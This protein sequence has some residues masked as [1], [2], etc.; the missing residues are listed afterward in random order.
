MTIAE[1][2]KYIDAVKNRLAVIKATIDKLN[3]TKVWTKIVWQT[4]T[5]TIEEVTEYTLNPK[6]VMSEYDECSKELR[7]AQ[8]AL[9]KV[10]HT[11]EVSFSAKY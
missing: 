7:L 11:T 3:L 4:A 6:A 5:S 8:A 2:I 9:E 1:L 10:N